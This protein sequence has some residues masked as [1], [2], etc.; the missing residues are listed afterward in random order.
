MPSEGV[1]AAFLS[2]KTLLLQ[3]LQFLLPPFYS[4]CIYECT[5]VYGKTKKI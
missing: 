5:F 2:F 1:S 4:V 3:N